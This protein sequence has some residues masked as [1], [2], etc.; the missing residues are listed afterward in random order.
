MPL[1]A[2]KHTAM[3][4]AKVAPLLRLASARYRPV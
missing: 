2:K 1:T 4:E 3:L